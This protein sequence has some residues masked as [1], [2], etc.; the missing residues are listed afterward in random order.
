MHGFGK[1]FYEN[2]KTAYEGQWENDEFNGQGRVYNAE[3]QELR[4]SF[5]F[6]DFSELGNQW[7]YY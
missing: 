1:L 5:N 2:G 7:V 4:E 3:P 6:K